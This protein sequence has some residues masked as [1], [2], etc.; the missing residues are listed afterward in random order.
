MLQSS[1]HSSSVATCDSTETRTLA[2]LRLQPLDHLFLLLSLR[3]RAAE[4]G[5]G[6]R[7]QI[8]VRDMCEEAV[9]S[10]ADANLTRG[11]RSRIRRHEGHRACR[12]RG[13]R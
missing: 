11:V 6:E 9:A 12:G 13:L 8:G 7:V 5:E 3:E 1:F 10:V 4:G 2:L